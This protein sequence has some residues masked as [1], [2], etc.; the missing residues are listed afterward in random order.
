MCS[1]HPQAQD[2][3]NICHHGWTQLGS[4]CFIYRN[5]A[6]DWATAETECIALKGNLA[7]IRSTTE[8]NFIRQLVKKAT[9]TDVNVWVGGYDAVRE[10][11]W[12]WSDGSKFTFRNWSRGEPNNAGGKEHCMEINY[13]GSQVNDVGCLDSQPYVCSYSME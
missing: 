1:L 2:C 3:G 4:R 10:G 13:A 8:Y 9:G 5:Q 11:V 6:Q 12:M 7:S